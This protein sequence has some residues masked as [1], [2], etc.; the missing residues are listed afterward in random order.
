M[1]VEETIALRAFDVTCSRRDEE[2]FFD[3]K[4]RAECAGVRQRMADKNY[5]LRLIAVFK[6]V[7]T[8]TSASR[9]IAPTWL[10]LAHRTTVLGETADNGLT[11]PRQGL[12]PQRRSETACGGPAASV[13]SRRSRRNRRPGHSERARSSRPRHALP[14]DRLT[15][16]RSDRSTFFARRAGP[17]QKL[18]L[19]ALW[20]VEAVPKRRHVP[21]LPGIAGGV[22]C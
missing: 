14:G 19:P 3:G 11:C 2:R 5:F 12:P 7:S 22:P 1:N 4:T 9:S 15:L 16:L 8:S 10:K 13:G 18:R 21:S 6:T 20:L 17:Y